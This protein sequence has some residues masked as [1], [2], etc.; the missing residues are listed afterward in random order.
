MIC[1]FGLHTPL[2][3][4]KLSWLEEDRQRR[5]VFVED[6]AISADPLL[7]QDPRVRIYWM[8]SPLQVEKIATQ[9]AWEAVFLP[10][11]ILDT[12]ASPSFPFFEQILR[13]RHAA[14]A[15]QLSDASDFGCS[16]AR[17]AKKNLSKK[18]FRS[19]LDL[20]NA[21]QDIPAIL[22]GA[23]PS[24]EK[25][26]HLLASFQSKAILFAGGH[27]LEKI[28]CR[29]HFGA[30]IDPKNPLSSMPYPDVP[31]CFQA[32]THPD[33]FILSRGK[34]LLAPD[35]HFSFLNFLSNDRDLFESGWTVGNF[36]AAL[37]ALFGCNPIVCVGMDYCYQNERKYAFDAVHSTEGLVPAIDG[38]GQ[39]VLTQSD[40]LMAV[41]WMED[42]AKRHPEKTFL[43]AT[44]GGM[45]Y[46]P[47]CKLNDLSFPEIPH[48]QENIQSA[49]SKAKISPPSQ[50]PMW[51]ESLRNREEI[52]Y[53]ELLLPL[54][55]IWKPIFAREIDSHPISFEEKMK[56]HQMIFF[57]NVIQEHLNV[58][59]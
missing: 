48:L 18:T 26:G 39:P 57:E 32:R 23:G 29:P 2:Y 20:Q 27:A 4:E 52:V 49:I 38:S 12:S 36:S 25:N 59:D 22:V 30:L 56:L 3:C 35:G 31:L 53:Q 42:F 17:N 14:A 24:L 55:N 28:P 41:S 46:L 21:F 44:E 34:T 40:W 5:L 19:I 37:A 16:L 6:R 50:W 15:L 8:E 7:L 11:E 45:Q 47:S 51:E 43:N 33:N 1:S 54:W 58:L 9:I 13:D 10:L